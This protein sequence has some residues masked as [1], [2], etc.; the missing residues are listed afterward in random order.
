LLLKESVDARSLD[1]VA[2]HPT[3]PHFQH[4]LGERIMIRSLLPSAAAVLALTAIGASSASDAA[5][6]AGGV[7][8]NRD[9]KDV[10]RVNLTPLAAGGVHL[11]ATASGLPPGIHAFHIHET[12]ECD[13]DGGFEAA[14]GHY[15]PGGS[16]HGWDVAEG[17]HAG[18]MPNIHVPQ[19]G[20]LALEYFLTAVSLEEDAPATLFDDDGSAVVIHQGA[21]DYSSQPSGA[22]G[23]RIVCAVIE[24]MQSE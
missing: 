17:A 2:F 16:E 9:G 19:S 11:V 3:G 6:S 5:E 8:L 24:H 21:D 10:G 20:D 14:G 7:M 1:C 4:L 23:D 12:G 13:A 22:A 15:N 18:D